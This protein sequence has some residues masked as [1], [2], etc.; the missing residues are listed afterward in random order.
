MLV[1]NPIVQ[2]NLTFDSSLNKLTYD[3]DQQPFTS[4]LDRSCSGE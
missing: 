2:K 1:R 4:F 3:K